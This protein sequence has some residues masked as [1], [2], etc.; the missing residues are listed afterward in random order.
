MEDLPV[1]VGRRPVEVGDLP[2]ARLRPVD[3]A[4][5]PV[6]MADRLPAASEARP[7]VTRPP[8]WDRT[9]TARRWRR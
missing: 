3:M 9:R 6:D 4:H 1:P 7:R 8:A 2:V 5:R